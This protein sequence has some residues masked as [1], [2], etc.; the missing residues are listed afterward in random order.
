MYKYTNYNMII[1]SRIKNYNQNMNNF[2][3]GRQVM[4]RRYHMTRVSPLIILAVF[5][6]IAIY[7]NP[8]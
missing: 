3:A 8:F 1:K 6:A 7:T 2:R 5:I 4:K